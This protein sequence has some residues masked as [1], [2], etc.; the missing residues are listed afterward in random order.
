MAREFGLQIAPH[1]WGSL[2]GFYAMLHVGC[3]VPNFY[4]AENDP[5]DT[6]VLIADGYPSKKAWPLCRTRPVSA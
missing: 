2:I 5:V 6:D 3:A 4:M 1:N